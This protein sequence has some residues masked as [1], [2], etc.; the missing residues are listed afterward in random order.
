MPYN[1]HCIHVKQIDDSGRTVFQF[2]GSTEDPV[3][4]ADGSKIA[5]LYPSFSFV[6]VSLP[7]PVPENSVDADIYIAKGFLGTDMPVIVCPSS[8][9]GVELSYHC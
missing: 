4:P 9:Y 2:L 6:A 1:F 7:C 3:T 5:F 8:Y